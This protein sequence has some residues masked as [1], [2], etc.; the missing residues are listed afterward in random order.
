MGTAG[1]TLSL[2]DLG[3]FCLRHSFPNPRLIFIRLLQILD[4]SKSVLNSTHLSNGS[5]KKK[6]KR[7]YI[8]RPLSA[9]HCPVCSP[10][11]IPTTYAIIGLP[12]ILPPYLWAR[13]CLCWSELI[14]KSLTQ[15]WTP[16]RQS[17]KIYWL[18]EW[19]YGQMD[20]W[21]ARLKS[22][23]GMDLIPCIF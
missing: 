7:S 14:P 9:P 1:L 4:L 23:G 22:P 8:P 16:R 3:S 15:L 13:M 10:Q 21:R 19:T 18:D 6:K 12:P 5:K 11:F 17:V 2:Q 20:R